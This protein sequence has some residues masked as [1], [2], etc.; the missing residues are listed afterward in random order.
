MTPA[1]AAAKESRGQRKELLQY[2]SIVE[3]ITKL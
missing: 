2:S 3:K 1:G